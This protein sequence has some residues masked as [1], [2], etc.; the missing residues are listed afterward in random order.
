MQWSDFQ[1]RSLNRHRADLTVRPARH[2]A[3]PTLLA[4]GFSKL[5]ERQYDLT[6]LTLWWKLRIDGIDLIMRTQTGCKASP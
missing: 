2:R 5:T 1:G 3:G 6:S 4:F